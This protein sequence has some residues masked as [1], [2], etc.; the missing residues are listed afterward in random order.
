MLIRLFSLL[1]ILAMA[2][3][4]QVSVQVST[5]K[6]AYLVGEPVWVV[7][8]VRNVGAAAIGYTSC[9]EHNLTITVEN[10]APRQRPPSLWGCSGAGMGGGVGGSYWCGPGDPPQ[11]AAGAST[12]YRSQL[13]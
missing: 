11:L 7:V 6:Q 12:S 2:A 9:V 5:T 13:T 4:C 10:T 8:E 1:A 3:P